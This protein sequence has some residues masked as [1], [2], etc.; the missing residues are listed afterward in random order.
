MSKLFKAF[1]NREQNDFSYVEKVGPSSVVGFW[2]VKVVTSEDF[3]KLG[4]ILHVA[5]DMLEA[6]KEISKE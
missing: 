3:L 1:H 5:E 2:H 6:V 4:K